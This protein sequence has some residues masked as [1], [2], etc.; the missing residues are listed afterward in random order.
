MNM[1]E[2]TNQELNLVDGAGIVYDVAKAVGK[3][4]GN[5]YGEYAN[6]VNEGSVPI[7]KMP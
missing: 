4:F 7:M 6:A 3:F 1:R 5:A 2:L